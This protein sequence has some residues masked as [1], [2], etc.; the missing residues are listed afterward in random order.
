M[1]AEFLHK[2]EDVKERL[3]TGA[4][5]LYLK[6]FPNSNVSRVKNTL[7]GKIQDETILNNLLKLAETIENL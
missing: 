6:A 7:A 1:T 3:P 4:V 2:L 5:P